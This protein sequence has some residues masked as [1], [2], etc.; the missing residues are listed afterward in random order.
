MRSELH[1]L[2]VFEDLE[3]QAAALHLQ[4][5][6]EAVDE[7]AR[8]HYAEVDLASRLHASVGRRVVVETVTGERV[9]GE[10]A[11]VGS[12]FCA[13]R[14]GQ[15]GWVLP[16]ATVTTISGLSARSVAE[17]A[18][19]VQARLSI[20]SVLRRLGED[21]AAVRVSTGGRSLGGRV[22]RVGQDF[23]ELLAAPGAVTDRSNEGPLLV[24]LARIE[25]LQVDA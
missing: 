17:A 13:L 11:R 23:F 14:S 15:R 16:L 1:L 9:D 2:D 25:A 7:V 22:G 3:Q 21:A 8:A 18:R 20:R 19:P 12:D 5:R 6:T 4:E 10:L 24:H